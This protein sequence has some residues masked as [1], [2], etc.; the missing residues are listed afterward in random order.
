MR[1]KFTKFEISAESLDQLAFFQE[2]P[3][4]RR[5]EVYR[6]C[7]GRE[8]D[9]GAE[10]LRHS[11]A[12]QDVY[13][14]LSGKAQVTVYSLSGRVV[15]FD[16]IG[17]GAMFGEMAAI[18][19]Q[20]RVASVSAV[21]VC[22]T[23]KIAPDTFMQLVTSEPALARYALQRLTSLIRQHC[24][25]ILEFHSLPVP[26]RIR[27]EF[28]RIAQTQASGRDRVVLAPRPKD[29]DIAN[30]VGTNREQ[31]NRER[32]S[33]MRR[34]LLEEKGNEFVVRSLIELRKE[35]S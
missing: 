5:G 25:R 26:A 14:L 33:L 30:R 15:I 22:R 16:E 20:P 23:I 18:D 27:A 8:Y 11:D 31:V 34:G 35:I 3:P 17:P 32:H 1:R 12:S 29:Q 9:A 2:L 10:I 28:L 13:F 7:E 19:Q 6:R 21:E 4:S 24:E